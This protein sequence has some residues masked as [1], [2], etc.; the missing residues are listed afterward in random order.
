[1]AHFGQRTRRVGAHLRGPTY[2][3]PQSY[4]NLFHELNQAEQMRTSRVLIDGVNRQLQEQARIDRAALIEADGGE[5]NDWMF[6]QFSL[7]NNPPVSPEG[8]YAEPRLHMIGW[9]NRVADTKFLEA[10]VQLPKPF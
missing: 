9:E 2:G 3:A 7:Y 1:M 8:I 5:H 10:F 4:C 6:P